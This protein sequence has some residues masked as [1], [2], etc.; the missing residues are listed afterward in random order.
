MIQQIKSS[1]NFVSAMPSLM[2]NSLPKWV[3]VEITD[4]STAGAKRATFGR[5][6]QPRALLLPKNF[7]T[8]CQTW[9]SRMYD[10]F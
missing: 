4:K 1:R 7:T 6:L 3:W 8:F 9:F 10:T 2:S 5:K